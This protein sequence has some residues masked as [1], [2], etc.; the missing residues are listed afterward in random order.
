MFIVNIAD[1]RDGFREVTPRDIV[2]KSIEDVL[3]FQTREILS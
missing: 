2:G 1:E 3:G